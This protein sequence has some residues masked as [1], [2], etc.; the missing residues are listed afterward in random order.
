VNHS[1]PLLP[2]DRSRLSRRFFLRHTALLGASAVII[3][4][5]DACSAPQTPAQPAAPAAAAQPTAQPAT[6]P[7]TASAA[8]PTT[9][10]AAAPTTAAAAPAGK[11]GGSL[12]FGA[13]Q[14]PDTMDPQ[15][16]GLAATS[17]ILFQT[18]T[19]LVWK[20]PDSDTFFPGLAERWEISP[21]GKEYTFY[22]RKDVKFHNGEPFNA[23]SV[24]FTFD[25]MANPE[26]K[27]LATLPQFDHTQKI[28]DYTAKVVFKQPYGPFLPLL[29][30]SVSYMPIPPK[31]AGER[32]DE[33]GLTPAGTGPFKM[34]EYVP[35]SHATLV[36][37]PDYNW[38]PE[39]YF[40]RNGA[41]YLDQIN[42]RI[43]EEP[44]TRVATLQSGETDMVEE[45]AAA[46][47]AQ[48][49]SNSQFQM[50][51]RDTLG[52]PRTIMLNNEKFPTDDVA[53]RQA[54]SYAVN[55]RTITDSVF[56]KTV[57][58][59]W[60]PIEPLTPGYNPAVEQYYAFDVAKA[61]DTL[62]KAGWTVNPSTGIREKDGKPLHALF[63][64]IT[65]DGMDEAAQVVQSN[66]KDVGID[67]ELRTES[68]PTV[69]NTYN[70]GDQNV[71][72]IFWWGTDPSSLHSL[73]HSS[74]IPK[75]FNWSHYNNPAVD[76]LLEEG[77]QLTDLQQRIPLYQ[78]AQKLIMDDAASI[79]LWG[80]RVII[81]AKKN[82]Q[83]VSWSQ[84]V[85]PIFYN[86][87]VNG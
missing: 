3:G 5:L 53:V 1:R 44:A 86:T 47:V 70:R 33:F 40:K 2:A 52:C 63:I 55:K 69:F 87:T 26:A 57:K 24:T 62:D 60:G 82:I 73:Y 29:S 16:T 10:P 85:Y 17:R 12:T 11:P 15:K 78:Q 66:F 74:N 20:F 30:A 45:V 64:V 83:N 49:E 18:L 4:V 9:A 23:D 28:D 14:T 72:N 32:P 35:K 81:G 58:P 34:T 43:V 48:I 22:L 54:M 6:K 61:K 27:T 37:N 59:A 13:W 65:N 38:A 56:K 76:K 71:A 68:E 36:R 8:A 75:G 79:P 31:Q 77:Q 51:Y 67:L 7:T 19:P 21:D 25:R 84:N 46:L 80:K 39:A 50:I 41:A 42:W